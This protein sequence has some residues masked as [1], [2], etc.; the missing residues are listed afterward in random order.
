MRQEITRKGA[1]GGF[2]GDSKNFSGEVMV[3]ML[4]T[5]NKWRNFS[6]GMVRFAPKARTAWHTHPAGQTLVVTEGIIYTGTRDGIVDVARAGD[7]IS[8]P[9][10]V[11]HWHGAGVESSGAHI[12]L[13]LEKDGT[14]GIW[15]EKLSDEEYEN[16]LAKISL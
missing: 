11:E 9:P 12:A 3:D 1:L 2:K 10:G 8:C 16:A 13:T 5:S 15:G 4:F 14:N 6:G 7:V